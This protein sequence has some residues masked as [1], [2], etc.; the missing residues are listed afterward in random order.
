MSLCTNGDPFA[1]LVVG[2]IAGQLSIALAWAIW[3]WGKRRGYRV[4]R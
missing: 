3:S 4:F 2:I 1:A